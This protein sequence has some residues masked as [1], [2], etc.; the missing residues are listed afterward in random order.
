MPTTPSADSSAM[1]PAHVPYRTPYAGA[2]DA[3]ANFWFKRIEL[4]DT[5]DMTAPELNLEIAADVA[6]LYCLKPRGV[7]CGES[8]IEGTF[9]EGFNTGLRVATALVRQP[10][11]AEAPLR[12]LLDELV[13][14]IR[15]RREKE[16]RS[17]EIAGDMPAS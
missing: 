3:L 7:T 11:D 14:V 1:P 9:E 10:F 12:Q 17:A 16:P 15:E 6:L 13:T 4:A 2:V 5:G 8:F